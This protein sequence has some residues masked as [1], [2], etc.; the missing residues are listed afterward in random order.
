M[1]R[2]ALSP[3]EIQALLLHYQELLVQAKG[4][5]DYHSQK[6]RNKELNRLSTAVLQ[7]TMGPIS[8]GDEATDKT[9]R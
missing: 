4:R 3:Q 2:R 5:K 7:Y 9:F 1:P 8:I 6:E